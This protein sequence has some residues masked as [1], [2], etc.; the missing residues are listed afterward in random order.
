[1][2]VK[3]NFSSKNIFSNPDIFVTINSMGIFPSKGS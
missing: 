2:D 3:L 1:M